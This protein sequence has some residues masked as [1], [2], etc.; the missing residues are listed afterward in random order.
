M[1]KDPTDK[2]SFLLNKLALFIFDRKHLA[3]TQPTNQQN[4]LGIFEFIFVLEVFN[5]TITNWFFTISCL[6]ILEMNIL[7]TRRTFVFND[8]SQFCLTGFLIFDTL[9]EHI[10]LVIN[11]RKLIE[12]CFH[13]GFCLFLSEFCCSKEEFKFEVFG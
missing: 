8:F 2:P 13:I 11:R 1:E 5:V 9:W 3:G 10:K 7:Q 4:A 12:F 6:V